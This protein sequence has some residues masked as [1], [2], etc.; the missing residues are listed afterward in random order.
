MILY[1]NRIHLLIDHDFLFL[2]EA[3]SINGLA[4]LTSRRGVASD[5]AT[6]PPQPIRLGGGHRAQLGGELAAGRRKL[7]W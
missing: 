5:L 2:S 1:Y 4:S 7:A 3:V 6:D